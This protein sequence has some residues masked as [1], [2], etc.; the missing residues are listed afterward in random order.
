[1]DSYY[2]HTHMG[3]LD[4]LS[5]AGLEVDALWPTA[6]W[7]GL[8]AF[9]EMALVLGFWCAGWLATLPIARTVT[10]GVRFVAHRPAAS[11]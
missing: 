2:H 1:M 11:H 9:A 3:T 7:S 5:D 4:A 6:D 10:S 8:Q